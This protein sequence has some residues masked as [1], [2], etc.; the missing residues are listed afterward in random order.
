MD[1]ASLI[2]DR[3]ALCAQVSKAPEFGAPTEKILGH[4]S[5]QGKEKILIGR[6]RRLTS[7]EE[8]RAFVAA[9]FPY[10]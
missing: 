10:I 3:F 5:T 1:I 4:L 2:G 9:P 7:A 8:V 6:A